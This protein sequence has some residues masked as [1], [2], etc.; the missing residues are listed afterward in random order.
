MHILKLTREEDIPI[1]PLT[2]PIFLFIINFISMQQDPR[3]FVSYVVGT[4]L[5]FPL[6]VI[7]ILPP[8]EKVKEPKVHAP[9]SVTPAMSPS[10]G[11]P[12]SQQGVKRHRGKAQK[13]ARVRYQKRNSAKK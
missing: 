5:V 11:Q 1:I 10:S 4:F 13:D 9:K 3:R 7:H 2:K 6:R 8:L 12:R